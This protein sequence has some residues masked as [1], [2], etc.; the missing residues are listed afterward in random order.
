MSEWEGKMWTLLDSV[1]KRKIMQQLSISLKYVSNNH[2]M[3]EVNA[4]PKTP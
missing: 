1:V 3:F 2:P 4:N